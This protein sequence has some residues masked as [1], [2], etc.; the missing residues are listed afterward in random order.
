[1][2][3]CARSGRRPA[4]AVAALAA[5]CLLAGPAAR[6]GTWLED[7]VLPHDGLD[8]RFRVYD[9][10][11]APPEG[12]PLVFVLHG[13]GGSMASVTDN[14]TMA[15]WPDIADEN[16]ILL[17][18]PNGVNPATGD[19]AG[20]DQNWN[21]CRADAPAVETG[22]D[23]V[24]FVSALI[25]W[26]AARWPIDPARVYATGASNGGM[27]SYRL[28]F[29]LSDR[30]AAIAAFIA[31]LPADSE[32]GEPA[33]PVPVFICN[34][35]AEDDYMPWDGGCV[36][37]ASGTC[38]RGTVIAAEATRD[39]WIAHLN[40]TREPTDMTAFPDLDPSDGST[41]ES[42]LHDGGF[43]AAEVAFYRVHGGGHTTPSIEHHRPAWL[44][45]LLGL[46]SQNH[47]IEGAREAWAFLARHRLDETGA[48][49]APGIA[50]FLRVARTG[51]GRLRLT[52]SGD[53]GSATRSAVYRGD[54]VAGWDSVAPEPGA[55]D[56][57]GHEALVPEGTRPAEFFVV[58]PHDGVTEGS[59]GRGS[60]GAPRAPAAGPCR[61]PGQT[62]AC[63][64]R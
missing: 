9:P 36:K 8:R 47:D 20:D 19:P 62:D 12:M 17:I 28:A 22:A 44:L 27:M 60:D 35:D 50:G 13:G 30:I 63:A 41:V 16:G 55:C 57:A 4:R 52:F 7:Q 42:A 40:T 38:R 11:F 26:A 2:P 53:C 34:G 58:V 33:H 37:A 24:G 6:A 59:Y 21:D 49:T 25:D 1:M 14:G 29:E 56:L 64:T 23:D 61:P 32:C 18:V 46:G 45:A 39:W 54:L 51:D 5:A 10:G 15:E 3:P 31:N 43:E 48:G